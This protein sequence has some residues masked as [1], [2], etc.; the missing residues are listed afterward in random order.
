MVS[1]KERQRYLDPESWLPPVVQDAA[2]RASFDEQWRARQSEQLE[3]SQRQFKE[4]LRRKP[5]SADEGLGITTPEPG[6][7][8]GMQSVAANVFQKDGK[9]FSSLEPNMP[10]SSPEEASARYKAAYY[11]ETGKLPED[12]VTSGYEETLQQVRPDVFPSAPNVEVDAVASD[13]LAVANR[14]KAKSSQGTPLSN[15]D[16]VYVAENFDLFEPSKNEDGSYSDEGHIVTPNW[17]KGW[18]VE[19]S[20]KDKDLQSQAAKKLGEIMS[21]SVDFK[22]VG[23]GRGPITDQD[24]VSVSQKALPEDAVSSFEEGVKEQ[25]NRRLAPQINEA[26]VGA[27][28]YEEYARSVLDLTVGTEVPS[29]GWLP[30]TRQSGFSRSSLEEDLRRLRDDPEIRLGETAAQKTLDAYDALQASGDI[31]EDGEADPSPA[32]GAVA[33]K[34]GLSFAPKYVSSVGP[35]VQKSLQSPLDMAKAS[36]DG[37]KNT[38]GKRAQQLYDSEGFL[39]I[40]GSPDAKL[41]MAIWN[42]AQ[43]FYDIYAGLLDLVK[44]DSL[45]KAEVLT[46]AY[47]DYVYD[48]DGG[49]PILRQTIDLIKAEADAEMGAQLVDGVKESLYQLGGA[50]RGEPGETADAILGDPVG[51]LANLVMIGRMGTAMSGLGIPKQKL[52]KFQRELGQFLASVDAQLTGIPL[53][54]KIVGGVVEAPIWLAGKVKPKYGALARGF[55]TS[56]TRVELAVR[57]AAEQGA[58][59]EKEVGVISKKIE[60][61]VDGGLT[62]AE[63]TAK[64]MSEVSPKSGDFYARTVLDNIGFSYG[65]KEGFLNGVPNPQEVLT[66]VLENDPKKLRDSLPDEILDQ[67][68][69]KPAMNP[70]NM[71]DAATNKGVEYSTLEVDPR[72]LLKQ[73]D[74]DIAK[75]PE[76]ERQALLS[77]VERAYALV[78]RRNLKFPLMRPGSNLVE[79]TQ[80]VPSTFDQNAG[81]SNRAL[82]LAMLLESKGR[83]VPITVRAD[84][85]SYFKGPLVGPPEV[86]SKIPVADRTRLKV[87]ESSGESKAPEMLQKLEDGEVA[88][89]ALY[90]RRAQNLARTDP[91]VF[92]KLKDQYL[93]KIG[94]TEDEFNQTQLGGYAATASNMIDELIVRAT[95]RAPGAPEGIPSLYGVPRPKQYVTAEGVPAVDP[96]GT[97]PFDLDPTMSTRVRQ[98]VKAPEKAR[99]E[100]EQMEI[101]RMAQAQKLQASE[102]PTDQ[103]A[104]LDAAKDVAVERAQRGE[105][106]FTQD[107]RATVFNQILKAKSDAD[108]ASVQKALSQNA[109]V[110]NAARDAAVSDLLVRELEVGDTISMGGEWP[111]GTIPMAFSGTAESVGAKMSTTHG[112]RGAKVARTLQPASP[113]TRRYLNAKEGVEV[114][115]P[116]FVNDAFER[117]SIIDDIASNPGFI[118][119]L[120][121]PFGLA[122]RGFTTRNPATGMGNVTSGLFLRGFVTGRFDPRGLALAADDVKLYIND[123]TSLSPEKLEIF[124]AMDDQG[125]F[126]STILSQDIINKGITRFPAEVLQDWLEGKSLAK[127]VQRVLD[128]YNRLLQKHE[129]AYNMTDPIFKVDHVFYRVPEHMNNAKR[130]SPGKYMDFDIEKGLS[131]RVFRNADG[132]LRYGDID[133]RVIPESEI[134]KYATMDAVKEANDMYFDYMD[135]PGGVELARKSGADVMLNNPVFTWGWKAGKLPFIK[136]GLQDNVTYGGKRTNTNDPGIRADIER[137][138]MADELLRTALIQTTTATQRDEDFKTPAGRELLRR[139][140]I[141]TPRQGFTDFG[142]TFSWQFDTSGGDVSGRQMDIGNTAVSLLV[143]NKEVLFADK[144]HDNVD[145]IDMYVRDQVSK[146]ARKSSMKTGDN[147]LVAQRAELIL[148]ERLDADPD[149]IKKQLAVLRR[150]SPL[151]QHD[152]I[153]AM[154]KILNLGKPQVSELYEI[155]EREDRSVMDSVMSGLLTLGAGSSGARD[156]ISKLYDIAKGEGRWEGLL[157]TLRIKKIPNR[158]INSGLDRI[159]KEQLTNYYQDEDLTGVG[160]LGRRKKLP[161][162]K[163]LD[164]KAR[165]FIGKILADMDHHALRLNILKDLPSNVPWKQVQ[166][167]EGKRLPSPEVETSILQ[168][169]ISEQQESK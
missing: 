90:L 66:A 165:Q 81:I 142:D 65:A 149:W 69:I 36:R 166:Y 167:E 158:Y 122:K 111:E 145:E 41:G 159:K 59:V 9:W 120:T 94:L 93:E 151:F 97:G 11:T 48:R 34:A 92:A 118:K 153:L 80:G 113:V 6:L 51:S 82:L 57:R 139:Y 47:K 15:D 23:Y 162:E 38:V 43:S 157:E 124:K 161:A 154:A 152:P 163:E 127:P 136:R 46:K 164:R 74:D 86:M 140:D 29:A 133:G 123:P 119:T 105:P 150:A 168:E 14:I 32:I 78:G 31:D 62:Q 134:R 40:P 63:A 160:V 79:G 61:N 132:T 101:D 125:V 98:T 10:T 169:L 114:A 17:F 75:L 20:R 84:E 7:G 52:S 108:V 37:W 141:R 72:P 8:E 155:A 77:E 100:L 5:P 135:V 12:V 115:V 26:G 39:G 3:E 138:R 121:K 129:K 106:A 21:G 116:N 18:V 130:L 146:A 91:E 33:G 55:F 102:A 104:G 126:S 103:A 19:T 60:E 68:G 143:K 25:R 56:P 117:L 99:A 49:R 16:L 128:R 109:K 76:A 53:A 87:Y 83:P 22:D 13:K 131:V 35:I 148:A 64:A 1:G 85:L 44:W 58:D 24:I 71:T 54:A 70:V 89:F 156:T 73:F 2:S 96:A 30:S 144:L 42:G 4:K 95:P 137:N 112:E 45:D 28:G 88:D 110:A 50:L 27:D 67:S 107:E 147:D